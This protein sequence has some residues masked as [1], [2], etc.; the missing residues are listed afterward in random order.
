MSQ[1]SC[2][3]LGSYFVFSVMKLVFCFIILWQK[4]MI[5][6]TVSVRS[7]ARVIQAPLHEVVLVLSSMLWRGACMKRRPGEY[8]IQGHKVSVLPH[9]FYSCLVHV[10]VFVFMKLL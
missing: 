9:Y 7:E 5:L 8:S 10:C 4:V 6:M 3:M 2:V 1:C